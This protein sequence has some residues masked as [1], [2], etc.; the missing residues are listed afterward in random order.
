MDVR[1]IQLVVVY[2]APDCMNQ[3]HQVKCINMIVIVH[4]ACACTNPTAVWSSREKG[5]G[6]QGPFVFSPRQQKS[7]E[8]VLY[9]QRK[10][11]SHANVAGTGCL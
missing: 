7:S 4:C 11:S 1:D 3:L 2:G 5:Y 8:G 9:F 6:I 10:L